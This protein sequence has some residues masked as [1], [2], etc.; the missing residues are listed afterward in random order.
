[1]RDVTGFQVAR[2]Q[3]GVFVCIVSGLGK[4][5]GTWDS[6]HGRT[7]A[8]RHARKLREEHP[9]LNAIGLTYRVLRTN[10]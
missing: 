2:Y 7:A 1:M 10:I 9:G 3:N 4:N 8:Y 5:R 6:V